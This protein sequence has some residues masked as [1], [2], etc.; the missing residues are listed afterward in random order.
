[1]GFARQDEE[2]GRRIFDGA[3]EAVPVRK[4]HFSHHFSANIAQIQHYY[5]PSPAMNK[6]ISRPDCL[7]RASASDPQQSGELRSRCRGGNRVK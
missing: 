7:F 2:N 6:K 3:F 5:T 4:R 1:M